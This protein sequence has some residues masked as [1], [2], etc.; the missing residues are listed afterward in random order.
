MATR[1]VAIFPQLH[2]TQYLFTSFNVIISLAYNILSSTVIP[3]FYRYNNICVHLSCYRRWCRTVARNPV[4]VPECWTTA[5]GGEIM[6]LLR[7]HFSY[8]MLMYFNGHGGR[9]E[10]IRA[11]FWSEE[12]F[13]LST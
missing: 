6:T 4:R 5:S 11:Y 8:F 7:E 1:R 12:G 10:A 13:L 3:S 9:I 2:A